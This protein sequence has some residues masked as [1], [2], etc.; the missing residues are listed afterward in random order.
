MRMFSVMCGLLLATTCVQAQQDVTNRY[1]QFAN[2]KVSV[3]KTVIYPSNQQKLKMHRHEKDRVLVAL[4][5]GKLKVTNDKGKVHYLNLE[6]DKAYYLLK[7][8]AGELHSDVNL[9]KHPVQV[10]VI[11]LE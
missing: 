4:T 7:D 9:S 8:E 6:K 5:D 11:E 2:D 10:M 1:P 3:W